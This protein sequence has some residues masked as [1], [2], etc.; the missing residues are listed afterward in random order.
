MSYAV[1]RAIEKDLPAVYDCICR[2]EETSFNYE[3][4][5][6]IYNKNIRSEDCICLVAESATN[7]IAGF[8]GCHIQ[9]LL[10]HCGKVAEIQEL[11]VAQPFRGLGIGKHLIKKM[12]Q[13][14]LAL[15]CVSFEVTAQNKR[16]ETHRFYE[17]LGFTPTHKKFV[18]QLVKTMENISVGNSPV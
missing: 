7:G 1:R 17:G 14:L 8:A 11:F 12:E 6:S 13:E 10:H 16:T 2:L 15:G 4:F 9:S 5:A 3:A 18:K